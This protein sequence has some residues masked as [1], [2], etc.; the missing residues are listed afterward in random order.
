MQ[1]DLFQW[2][3]LAVGQG[4]QSLA[5]LDFNGAR[6]Y[7]TAVLELLPDHPDA[8]QGMGILATWEDAFHKAEGLALEPAAGFFWDR[9]VDFHFG[10]SES[11]RTLR[12]SLIRHLLTLM[13]GNATLYI[14]PDLCSGYLY[15]QLADYAAAEKHLRTL[16]RHYPEN[17]RLLGYLADALLMQGRPEAGAAYATALLLSPNEVAVTSMGDRQLA[18]VVEEHGPA[19]APIHGFLKGILPLV[20]FKS[21]AITREAEMYELLRQA[22]LACHRG[23]HEAM[24]TAR[25]GIKKLAPEVLKHYLETK[26]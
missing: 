20:E 24:I 23:D 25:A 26:R 21:K 8:C 10:N 17:G 6:K 9:I 12:L 13:D 16:V 4:Y 1:L 7:F 11:S 15:L 5:G 18:E 22:E 19:M 2:D 3:I 14:P